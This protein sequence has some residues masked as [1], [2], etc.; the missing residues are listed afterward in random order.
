MIIERLHKNSPT[1]SFIVD[2]VP[3]FP[4]PINKQ[5]IFSYFL[6][7]LRKKV[8]SCSSRLYFLVVVYKPGC[9]TQSPTKENTW[10]RLFFQLHSEK[11]NEEEI[12]FWPFGTLII[13]CHLSFSFFTSFFV[14]IY[15]FLAKCCAAVSGWLISFRRRCSLIYYQ[16]AINMAQRERKA[17]HHLNR[18]TNY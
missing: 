7:R 14:C 17:A 3:D 11:K 12:E 9:A 13:E 4:Y 15:F 8:P 5:E 2:L 18:K 6:L 16:R 10:C 1:V